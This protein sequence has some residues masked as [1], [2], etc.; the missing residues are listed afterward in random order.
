MTL[1]L[2]PTAK[3]AMIWLAACGVGYSAVL[4]GKRYS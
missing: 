3:I 4:G 2:E 1:Q